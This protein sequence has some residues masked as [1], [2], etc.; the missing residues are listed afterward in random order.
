MKV[1]KGQSIQEIVLLTISIILVSFSAIVLFGES[2]ADIF[3]HSGDRS[4]SFNKS[5]TIIKED[6]TTILTNTTLTFNGKEYKSPLETV[7]RS[8]LSSSRLIETSGGQGNLR[9]YLEVFQMYM[10]QFNDII[11]EQNPSN[12]KSINSIIKEYTNAVNEYIAKDNMLV[13]TGDDPLLEIINN[14]DITLDIH[15]DGELAKKLQTEMDKLLAGYP[16]GT[17]KKLIE[18]FSNDI[19]NFGEH[20]DYDIDSRVGSGYDS[21]FSLQD[22]EVGILMAHNNF[23]QKYNEIADIAKQMALDYD[24]GTECDIEKE[25]PKNENCLLAMMEPYF[26]E[27]TT[28][29]CQSGS[30]YGNCMPSYDELT[31][32]SGEPTNWADPSDSL[33]LEQAA[34]IEL[35]D[36][37]VLSLYKFGSSLT[38]GRFCQVWIDA[39]GAAVGPNSTGK[40]ILGFIIL[41]DGTLEPMGSPTYYNYGDCHSTGRGYSCTAQ[42]VDPNYDPLGSINNIN[43]IDSLKIL[44]D[45]VVRIYNDPTISVEYKLD[46]AKRIE[47]FRNGTYADIFPDSFNSEVL[48]KGIGASIANNQCNFKK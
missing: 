14:L 6:Q 37:T 3:N 8:R 48:C 33:K 38:K 43:S 11:E 22:S 16:D 17:N 25:T 41:T 12:K 31:Y 40:D 44:Y 19:L 4:L 23:K 32:Y 29:S 39:N 24:L 28:K 5:R 15:K 36:K 21:I 34:G 20:I 1:I 18:T 35:N 46:L 27:R 9:E 2:I 30:N 42:V 10:Q 47:I 45:E 7:V 13:Q 26:A